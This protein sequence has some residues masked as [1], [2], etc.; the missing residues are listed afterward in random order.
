MAKLQLRIITADS[1]KVDEPVDMIIMRCLLE[2]MGEHSAMGEIGVLPNHMPLSGVLGINPL[3]IFN[4]GTERRM[5]LFGGV[6]TIRDNV[7]TLMTEQALWSDE[8]DSTTAKSD[9][10]TANNALSTADPTNRREALIA[11]RQAS[12]LVEVGSYSS[13]RR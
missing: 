10:D 8:I 13:T 3:R 6:V 12:V 5:A 1:M 7:A 11:T 4:D 2:D 9:L